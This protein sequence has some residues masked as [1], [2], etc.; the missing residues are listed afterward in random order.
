MKLMFEFLKPLSNFFTFSPVYQLDADV[1]SLGILPVWPVLFPAQFR[2][3]GW[4]LCIPAEHCEVQASPKRFHS[5]PLGCLES[6]SSR[7]R[8]VLQNLQCQMRSNSVGPYK[9]NYKIISILRSMSKYLKTWYTYQSFLS[10]FYLIWF[11]DIDQKLE[12]SKV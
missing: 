5:P 6:A 10:L 4:F 9:K 3:R 12:K 2:Y 8:R 11:L 1:A 7:I